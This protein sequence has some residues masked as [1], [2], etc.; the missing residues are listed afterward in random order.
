MRCLLLVTSVLFAAQTSS[1]AAQPTTKAQVQPPVFS[2][3]TGLVVVDF[4]VTA[5]G[6]KSVG[7]MVA[8]DFVVK[9]DGKERPIVSFRAFG[10]DEPVIVEAN[11]GDAAADPAAL[12]QQKPLAVAVLVIDD[13]QLTFQQAVR[14][15][16]ALKKILSSLAEKNAALALV[17]PWSKISLAEQVDGNTAVFGAAVDQIVGR[18]VEDRGTFPMADAEAFAIERGDPSMLNRL[19]LRFVALN[20][21][22]DPDS[23][24][25]AAR[26]RASEVSRDARNRR[27]DLYGVLSKS[28]EW[29]SH[30]PGRHSLVMVTGGFAYDDDDSKR[31]EL[32]TQSLRAN[33]PVHFLDAR[34]LQG[35]GI[36][37]GVEY[38]PALDRD[39]GETSFAWSEAAEGS[40]GLALDTG[41]IIIRNTNDMSKG[42]G[43]LMDTMSTYYVLA[44][45]PPPH[46]K[47]G[48]RKIKV[49]TKVKGLT[50][51]A[52]RGY[53]D[54]VKPGR[55]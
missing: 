15:R 39:A 32:I 46:S 55:K 8:G 5:K 17:A 42:L 36:F 16:P 33:A 20:P 11:P 7:G 53:F 48:F 23:A 30:Q 10:G 31:E 14:L 27:A 22:F 4:V 25:V 51:V 26:G 12:A 43:L 13:G 6:D 44:Y 1:L 47:S 21:G 29:L 3:G 50:I 52:R 34:G 19:A 18:R 24:A 38:G 40:T 9:E 28:L 35:M 49:E 45:E 41:G 2:A 37:Q 54:E